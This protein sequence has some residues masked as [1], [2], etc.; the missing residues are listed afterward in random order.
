MSLYKDRIAEGLCGSCGKVEIE[1]GSLCSVCKEKS[2]QRAATKRE[3]L[4]QSGKCISCGK[5][6]PREGSTR[7]EHCLGHQR[8]LRGK[9]VKNWKTAGLCQGCGKAD[10]KPN[11]TLCQP[12]MDDRSRVSSKHYRRRKEAGTCYYC[13]QPPEPDKVLCAYHLEQ[14]ADYR[15]QVKLD[16]I[17]AY[18]G[19]VCALCGYDN[20][21]ETLEIDHIAGGSRAHLREL[22]L[23]GPMRMAA[24]GYQFYLWLRREGYPEGFR[25]LCPTCNKQAHYDKSNK[26]RKQA[27]TTAETSLD[28]EQLP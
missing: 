5:R 15:V 14:H 19:R 18:G 12:C 25:V 7:C 2:R 26:S 13:D 23:L 3:K 21:V 28:R 6:Q 9:Q 16:A 27:P 17:D 10:P 1:S 8:V 4:K 24:A 22:G 11:C 20:V